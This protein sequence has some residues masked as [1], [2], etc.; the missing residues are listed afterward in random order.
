[1]REHLFI[2]KFK[3]KFI[4]IFINKQLSFIIRNKTLNNIRKKFIIY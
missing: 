4:S 2:F 1:M 3:Y